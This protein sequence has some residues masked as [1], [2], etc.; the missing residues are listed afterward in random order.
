MGGLD[1]GNPRMVYVPQVPP[2]SP[3]GDKGDV[4]PGSPDLLPEVQDRVVSDDL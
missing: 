1:N 4:N 3:E 2:E